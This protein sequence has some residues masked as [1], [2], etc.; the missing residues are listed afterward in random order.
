MEIS[1]KELIKKL[2][3]IKYHLHYA[4]LLHD[5]SHLQAANEET[6]KLLKNFGIDLHPDELPKDWLK[7]D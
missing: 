1:E 4:E 2:K 3:R 7:N 5:R 6:N